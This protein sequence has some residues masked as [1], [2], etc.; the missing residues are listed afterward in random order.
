MAT[1]EVKWIGVGAF[2]DAA[3]LRLGEPAWGEL[4]AKLPQDTRDL[5]AAPPAPI[6]W[7]DAQHL[8]VIQDALVEQA[9]SR[10]DVLREISRVQVDQHLRGIYRVFVRLASPEFIAERAATLYKTYWR[11]NGTLRVERSGPKSFDVIYDELPQ[12]RPSWV[13]AQ[14]GAI[15]AGLEV[16]GLSGVRVS[17]V[18]T[19]E[20]GVRARASWS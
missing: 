20:H 9:N 7:I 17:V 1:T 14:L 2:V 19:F 13:S 8:F 15:Q 12:V 6:A 3:R 5:L 4:V 16:S 18:Q 10:H 11:N